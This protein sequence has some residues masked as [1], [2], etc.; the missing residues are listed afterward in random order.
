MANT[1]FTEPF[2]NLPK[3]MINHLGTIA[4]SGTKAFMEVS[5][6]ADLFIAC[7]NFR[8]CPFSVLLL[9]HSVIEAVSSGAD[10]SMIG[11]PS[12]RAMTFAFFEMYLVFL[13]SFPRQFIGSL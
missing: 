12:D 11:W 10:M 6:R 4:K 9:V 2:K 7:L 5:Y 3:E 8:V 1:V 13:L